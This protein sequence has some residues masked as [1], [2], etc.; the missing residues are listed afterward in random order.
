MA[1]NLACEMRRAARTKWQ[2]PILRLLLTAMLSVALAALVLVVVVVVVVVVVL[3]T[4]AASISA[5]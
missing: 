3:T 1:K 5:N 2:V 4:A